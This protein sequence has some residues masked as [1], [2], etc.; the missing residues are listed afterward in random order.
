MAREVCAHP[1]QVWGEGDPRSGVWENRQNRD[2]DSSSQCVD[3]FPPS[4][5][6]RRNGLLIWWA[7]SKTWRRC[8]VARVLWSLFCTKSMDQ[9]AS[10]WPT[11]LI[12]HGGQTHVEIR[13][14]LD[15]Q[16]GVTPVPRVLPS[17]HPLPTQKP[18]TG[19]D[20]AMR[21]A[22]NRRPQSPLGSCYSQAGALR[23]RLL[24]EPTLGSVDEVDKAIC[25]RA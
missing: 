8:K 19:D 7:G 12:G 16:P 5:P 25:D 4:T 11:R 13:P 10:P 23:Y 22:N 1:N 15:S 17:S 18:P 6:K 2:A 21:P 24:A 9:T 14:M 3:G 20:A